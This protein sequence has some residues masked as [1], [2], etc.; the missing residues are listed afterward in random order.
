VL[1]K[2]RVIIRIKI[3]GE[4]AVRNNTPNDATMDDAADTINKWNVF[5]GT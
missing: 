2:I 5:P 1:P 4:F 3:I